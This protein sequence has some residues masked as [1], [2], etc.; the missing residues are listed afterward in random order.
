[1]HEM[2]LCESLVEIMQQHA[3]SQGFRQVKQVWVEVGACAGVEIPALSF[4][5][6]VVCR[7]TLAENCTLN[8]INLPAQALCFECGKTVNTTDR[9][10]ACPDCGAYQMIFKGGDEFRIKELEV[11]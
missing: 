1:M 11:I 2:S 6:D 9:P 7:N 8:I 4:C 10:D 5:F 3:R